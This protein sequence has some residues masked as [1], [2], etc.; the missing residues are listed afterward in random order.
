VYKRLGGKSR[1]LEKPRIVLFVEK[2]I[3]IIN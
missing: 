3:N 2:E 1:A